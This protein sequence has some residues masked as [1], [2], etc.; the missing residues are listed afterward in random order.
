M[1]ITVKD[2]PDILAKHAKWLRLE[3]G[4]QRADLQGADLQ[5]ALLQQ[6]DLQG[7]LLQRADLRGADLRGAKWWDGIV[8]S[9]APLFVS[10]LC[11]PVWILDEHMQI[12]CEIHRLGEWAAFDNKQIASMDGL[13]TR[14]FWDQWKIAL[15]AM[16]AADGR[17][18]TAGR[19]EEFSYV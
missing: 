11:W 7:A 14:K 16:A 9:R 4:G 17:G 1:T 18:V 10:G 12:G 6:A 2:L 8:I 15:L 3:A 13:A 19:T 5:G